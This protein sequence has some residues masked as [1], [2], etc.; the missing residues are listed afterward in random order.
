MISC[1]CVTSS[2]NC[3]SPAGSARARYNIENAYNTLKDLTRGKGGINRESLKAFIQALDIPEA[4][5]EKLHKLSLETYIGRLPRWRRKSAT[6]I[7]PPRIQIKK[8]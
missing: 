8:E 3:L 2:K 5:K 7:E 1:C 6:K 4:E